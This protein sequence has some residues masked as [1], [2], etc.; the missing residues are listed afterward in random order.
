MLSSF[1]GDL[2]GWY[3][4]NGS[5]ER[6][7][8]D[9]WYNRVFGC[10]IAYFRLFLHKNHYSLDDIKDMIEDEDFFNDIYED[11]KQA[12]EYEEGEMQIA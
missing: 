4:T 1:V 11:Y 7:K 10:W 3:H 6:D 2:T 8:A 12:S 9:D 5:D